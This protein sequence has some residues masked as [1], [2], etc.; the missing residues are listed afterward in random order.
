MRK[1]GRSDYHP[2]PK[3]IIHFTV[4]RPLL[5]ELRQWCGTVTLVK[6]KSHTGCLLNEL[7]DE[8]AELGRANEGSEICPG[9]QK[10]GSFWLRVSQ[11]VREYAANC[12]VQL[13][14]DSAPN[15]SLLEKV[16][17]FNTLRAVK[18][19]STPFVTDLLQHKEGATV[20]KIIQ[21]CTP[22]EYLVWLRCMTGIYLVQTYLKRIG[23]SKSPTCLHCSEGVPETLT[24]FA[25][26]CPKFREARTSAHN[27]VR[28]AITLLLHSI[29]GPEWELFE[30]TPVVRTG[31]T[32]RSNPQ[33]TADQ[34]G[35]RQPDW[36]AISAVQKRI[37]IMDLCH[38]S[39]VLPTQLLAAALRKQH[40]YNPL[41]RL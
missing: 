24:H 9:P 33:A 18:K 31:L 4:L 22:A 21:R 29:L 26:V 28:T 19:R 34:L 23:V 13:P 25:C 10:Y 12:G 41:K 1:W 32:L 15:R 3:E 37:A 38:P 5:E 14:R 40:A 11:Q 20:S 36:I 7:A 27:Q 8:H 2:G 6:V 35:H 39:D 16:A 30:E 17:N